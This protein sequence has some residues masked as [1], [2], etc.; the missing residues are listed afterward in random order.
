MPNYFEP[1]TSRAERC[2]HCHDRRLVWNELLQKS[3][4]CPQC[5]RKPRQNSS[6]LKAITAV[7]KRRM[8][9]LVARAVGLEVARAL[10][11]RLVEPGAVI[12]TTN[13]IMERWAVG[14]GDGLPRTDEE[15][16][17]LAKD[18]QEHDDTFAAKQSLPPPLDDATQVVIDRIVQHSPIEIRIF[19]QQWFCSSV[20]CVTMAKIRGLHHEEIY[21]QWRATLRYLK[22]QFETSDHADLVRLVNG[23]L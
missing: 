9:R 3:I 11:S 5:A 19:A 4:R 8:N 2:A 7:E 6:G 13:R 12:S 16:D 15:L 1:V 21:E 10:G 20:P 18:A 17:Q 23:R 14:Y 22:F